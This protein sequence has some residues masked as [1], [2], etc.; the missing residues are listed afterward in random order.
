MLGEQTPS[1]ASE[2]AKLLQQNIVEFVQNISDWVRVDGITSNICP[3]CNHG[4]HD[5]LHPFNCSPTSLISFHSPFRVRF[6]N[7]V[8]EVLDLHSEG[9]SCDSWLRNWFRVLPTKRSH[10]DYLHQQL[11]LPNQVKKDKISIKPQQ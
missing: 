11:E 7:S 1:V 6:D 5:T 2:E 9:S 3:S 8:E 4:Q 10:P